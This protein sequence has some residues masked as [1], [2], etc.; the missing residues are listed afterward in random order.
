MGSNIGHSQEPEE[1]SEENGP[2]GG[3][4]GGQ[5]RYHMTMT[6]DIV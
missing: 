1:Y 4:G 6:V 5:I 3:G 2:E